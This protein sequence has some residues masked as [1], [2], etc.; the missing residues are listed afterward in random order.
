VGKFAVAKA[1][2]IA[3][4]SSYVDHQVFVVLDALS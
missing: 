2:D 1:L 3:D 4:I